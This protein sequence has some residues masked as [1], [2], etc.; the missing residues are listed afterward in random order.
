MDSQRLSPTYGTITHPISP[1]HI[2]SG[3]TIQAP[4]LYGPSPGTAAGNALS[5]TISLLSGTSGGAAQ[6]PA[7]APLRLSRR[8]LGGFCQAA[9]PTHQHT[10]DCLL[11]SWLLFIKVSH[12]KPSHNSAVHRLP[13]RVL[14]LCPEAQTTSW[15]V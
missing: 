1:S 2:L 8:G 14:F 9:P 7:A 4:L 10:L 6:R 15:E 5:C 13:A 3:H 11:E 12:H